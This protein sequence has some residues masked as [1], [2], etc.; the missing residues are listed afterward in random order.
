MTPEYGSLPRIA[1]NSVDFPAPLRPMIAMISPWATF[2]WT[3][4][5][6]KPSFFLTLRSR[7]S[8]LHLQS[9]QLQPAISQV[10]QPQA[11]PCTCSPAPGAFSGKRTVCFFCIFQYFL[12]PFLSQDRISVPAGQRPRAFSQALPPA[13]ASSPIPVPPEGG[14]FSAYPDSAAWPAD[15][16]P[17]HSPP[18]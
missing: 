2:K 17:D 9:T 4:S 10:L 15:K 11:G 8:M 12:P 14:P 16:R 18:W 6:I 13:A 1:F 7:I 3:F 5:R